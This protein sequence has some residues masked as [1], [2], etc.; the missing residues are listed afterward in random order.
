MESLIFFF[1]NQAPDFQDV[2]KSSRMGDLEMKL[3]KNCSEG[4]API[5]S[6]IILRRR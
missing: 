4:M 3:V 1:D 5:E 2:R 6:F